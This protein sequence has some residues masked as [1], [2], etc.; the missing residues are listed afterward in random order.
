MSC[1]QNQL[2]I[3]YAWVEAYVVLLLTQGESVGY[4]S[5]VRY[6][7]LFYMQV[8]NA[9]LKDNL[10]ETKTDMNL[11]FCGHRNHMKHLRGLDVQTEVVDF[12]QLGTSSL[13]SIEE[14]LT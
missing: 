7:N 13:T 3:K 8:V 10:T 5:V 6:G 4:T 1:F 2:Y 14:N 11:L 12:A 9:V